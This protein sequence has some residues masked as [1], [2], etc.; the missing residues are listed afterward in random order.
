MAEKCPY[1]G[2][3]LENGILWHR[4][5]LFVPDGEK[6][7]H[8]LSEKAIKKRRAIELPISD[9][10]DWCPEYPKAQ[11]CRKCR[12]IIIPYKDAPLF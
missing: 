12:K 3:D 4:G 6:I 2:E 5:G 7:P 11:A 1:C 9:S 8:I 10:L